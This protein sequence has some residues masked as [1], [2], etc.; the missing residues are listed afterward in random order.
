M[1]YGGY[2]YIEENHKPGRDEFVTV[3]WVK[4]KAPFRTLAEALASESSVGTWTKLSTMNSF[5]WEKLRARV[6]RLKQVTRRSGFVF[7]A[8]PYEHFDSSNLL[9]I[10]ASIR[11][12]IYGL[13]ELQECKLLD[14]KSRPSFRSSS[15]DPRSDSKRSGKGSARRSGHMLEQ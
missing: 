7:V 6:F 10:L 14:W 2:S 3:L 11:G 5:V 1:V 12:N 8:Y 13:K 15:P 9:Q 4:G